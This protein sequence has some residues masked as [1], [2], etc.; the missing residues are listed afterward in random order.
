ME[1]I[2]GQ[3]CIVREMEV[4]DAASIVEWRNRPDAS[5]WLV[6]WA[7]LTIQEHSAWFAKAIQQ[8]L[9]F[10][11]CDLTGNLV[12]TASLYDFDRHRTSAQ[13]GR[14]CTIGTKS[15]STPL[16]EGC[17]LIHRIAFE[18]LKVQRIYCNVSPHNY[19]SLFLTGLLGYI[20]EGFRRRH[21]L[22]PNGYKDVVEFGLFPDE[23]SVARRALEGMLYSHNS[24]PDLSSAASTIAEALKRSR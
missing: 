12:G 9:I 14:V 18:I 7:P 3:Y 16:R 15:A 2:R 13:C 20:Q 10:V 22:T 19:P 21:Q 5:R 17:Y 4:A 1:L 11:F 23:F 8:D 24:P 6:Q